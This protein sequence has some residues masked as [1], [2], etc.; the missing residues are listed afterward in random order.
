[1]YDLDTSNI[2]YKDS[3]YIIVRVYYED[4]E[5]EEEVEFS[6]RENMDEYLEFVNNIVYNIIKD[7]NDDFYSIH[8]IRKNE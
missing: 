7:H 8:I 5:V 4:Y 1:M 3:Q 6:R 2:S